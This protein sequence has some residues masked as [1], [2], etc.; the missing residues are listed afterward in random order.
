VISSASGQ[1]VEDVLRAL[2]RA[3]DAAKEAE[4]P[5]AQAEAW[6]P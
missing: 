6:R 3:V 5:L 1:G 4:A 2:L